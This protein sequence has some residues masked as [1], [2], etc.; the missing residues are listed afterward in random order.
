MMLSSD[1]VEEK[2]SLD[3]GA[4]TFIAKPF[5]LKALEQE[6]YKVLIS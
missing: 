5:D 2:K 1:E 3:L 4:T 6:I